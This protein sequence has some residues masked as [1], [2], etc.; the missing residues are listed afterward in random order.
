MIIVITYD[1]LIDK[2]VFPAALRYLAAAEFWCKYKY[3]QRP[4]KEL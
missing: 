1:F 3:D 4:C 2:T